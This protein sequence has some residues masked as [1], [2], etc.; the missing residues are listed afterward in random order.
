MEIE[1]ER[2]NTNP[3]LKRRELHLRLRY[4]KDPTPSRKA[5]REKVA[6]LFNVS[7]DRI[8]VSY[9]KPQFGKSEAICY[10]KIYESN[11]DLLKTEPKYVI[12]RNFEAETEAE[13]EAEA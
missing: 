6:G 8:V 7:L 13:T 11:E 5:V 1:V 2:D 12:T 4:E 10:V 3:L 9:I